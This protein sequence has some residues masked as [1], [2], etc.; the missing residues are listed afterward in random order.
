MASLNRERTNFVLLKIAKS[1]VPPSTPSNFTDQE[2]IDLLHQDGD[3]GI[4]AIFRE[5]Y[6]FVTNAVYKILPDKQLAEDLAQ[7]VF[8][9]LWKKREALIINTSLRAYLK[10]AAVNKTLNYIRDK[11]MNFES[12]EMLPQLSHPEP[13][14]LAG[15][16]MEE[17]QQRINTLIDKLPERCRIVFMLSRF[18][19]LSHAEIAREL[20]ISP[21]TVENQITKALKFL[22]EN[23]SD[24]REDH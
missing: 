19:E 15:M 6:P 17:L 7:D 2:L 8:F 24:L 4:E 12:D 20:S 10:R 5:H 1:L 11:K 9:E 23:L 14:S 13:G 21:K 22:K 16:E 18:E 3:K